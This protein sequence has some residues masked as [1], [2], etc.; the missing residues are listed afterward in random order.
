MDRGNIYSSER[1][2]PAF[3]FTDHFKTLTAHLQ[4]GEANAHT[5]VMSEMHIKE[6]NG[7]EE[8][9]ERGRQWTF[10]G[11]TEFSVSQQTLMTIC[12]KGRGPWAAVWFQMCLAHPLAGEACSMSG[13]IF[14]WLLLWEVEAIPHILTVMSRRG[15]NAE[16]QTRET[17]NEMTDASLN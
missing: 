7:I 11:H 15:Q 8:W 3:S 6:E 10:A 17:Q 16:E 14:Q 5:R 4:Q 13:D 2:E 1:W 9:P 12:L